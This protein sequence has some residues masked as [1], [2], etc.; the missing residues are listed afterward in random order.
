MKL[1][2][3]QKQLLTKINQFLKSD[4]EVFIIK[5][6][7][8]SGKTFFTKLLV[9]SFEKNDTPFLL[10]APTGKSAKVLSQK[11]KKKVS[12]IHSTI[13]NLKNIKEDNENYRFYFEREKTFRSDFFGTRQIL[14]KN[15]GRK[16]Y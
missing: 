8:G 5:G 2:D 7:A 3:S 1:T 13:Y 15:N 10:M 14:K 6:Y 11:T 9:D 4:K 16:W 12:T